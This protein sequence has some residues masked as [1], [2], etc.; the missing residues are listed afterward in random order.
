MDLSLRMA[1]ARR[2]RMMGAKRELIGD[3][4]KNDQQRCR[5]VQR[6]HPLGNGFQR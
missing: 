5:S 6:D 3:D 2:F 1:V 4:A